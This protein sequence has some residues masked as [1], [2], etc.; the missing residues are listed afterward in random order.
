M[1][2]VFGILPVLACFTGLNH[3]LRKSN[4]KTTVV[5]FI[6]MPAPTNSYTIEEF[7]GQALI[8]Q[9]HDTVIDI[10]KHIGDHLLDYALRFHR[11][12]MSGYDTI[13]F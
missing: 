7:K 5:A 12:R 1:S 10:Q 11:C 13:D 2:P 3:R 9:L 4:S 8:R 6:I